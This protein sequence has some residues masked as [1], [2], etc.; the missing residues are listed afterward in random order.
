[1]T[2]SRSATGPARGQI[3]HRQQGG[4]KIRGRSG[5]WLN[6]IVDHVRQRSHAGLHLPSS[7]AARYDK[8]REA[9]LPPGPTRSRSIR[10]REREEYGMGVEGVEKVEGLLLGGFMI[11]VILGHR[12]WDAELKRWRMPD[13]PHRQVEKGISASWLQPRIRNSKRG[14]RFAYAK[15]SPHPKKL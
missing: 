2:G 10:Q 12:A 5:G 14:C 3:P 15:R 4:R 1:M 7:L 6:R 9:F 8:T 11:F 13:S